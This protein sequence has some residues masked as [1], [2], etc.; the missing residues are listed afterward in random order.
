MSWVYVAVTAA[1]VVASFVFRPKPTQATP[2]ELDQSRFPSVK[3][4][5]P[6]IKAVGSP[7]IQEWTVLW[8]GHVAT[9]PVRTDSG[10]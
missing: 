8:Y 4:G 7:L 2:Q 1:L 5:K 9:E 3:D 10:K 6:V